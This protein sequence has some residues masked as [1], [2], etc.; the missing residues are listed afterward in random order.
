M[1]GGLLV[2]NAVRKPLQF[3]IP[4]T[5]LT[6]GAKYFR[7]PLSH[8]RLHSPPM[9]DL[10]SVLLIDIT[11]ASSVSLPMPLG[12]LGGAFVAARIRVVQHEPHNPG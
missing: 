6:Q 10:L 8:F 11:K 9:Q 2:Q 4:Y 1:A 3:S 7:L 5:F 12:W